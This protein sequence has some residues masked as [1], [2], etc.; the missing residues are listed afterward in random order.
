MAVMLVNA[1]EA[2]ISAINDGTIHLQT[3]LKLRNMQ[4]RQ[5][6]SFYGA[7]VISGYEDGTFP[8]ENTTQP[9][10]EAAQMVYKILKIGE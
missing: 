3:M 8:A 5:L 1:Y 4:N 7:G 9:D 6:Q 2:K 10:A